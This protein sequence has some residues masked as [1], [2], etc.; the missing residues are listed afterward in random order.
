MLCQ[1]RVNNDLF[2]IFEVV[3]FASLRIGVWQFK[4]RVLV[5][6]PAVWFFASGPSK[7]P[8]TLLQ[9]H[10]RHAREDLGMSQR[11]QARF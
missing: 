4:D 6:K 11:L 3:K 5:S 8:L 1:S 2:A 10:F 7:E 9:S